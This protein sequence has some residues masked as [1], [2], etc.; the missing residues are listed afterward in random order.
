[1][2]DSNHS[3]D[4][5][6]SGAQKEILEELKKNNELLEKLLDIQSNVQGRQRKFWFVGL[7]QVAVMVVVLLWFGSKYGF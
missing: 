3:D 6:V 4:A 7:F 1:M 2:A 5:S